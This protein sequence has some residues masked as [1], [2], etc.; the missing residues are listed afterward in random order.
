MITSRQDYLFYIQEDMRVNKWGEVSLKTHL[1]QFL[2]PNNCLRLF[3]FYLRKCEYYRNCK[4]SLLSKILYAFYLNRYSYYSVMCGFTIPMNVFGPGLSIAHRGTIVINGAAKIGANCR[5]HACVNIGTAK[6]YSTEAPTIGDN[7]YIGPGAK[8]FG[9]IY[10]AD[11][12]VI[13]ANAVVN[14][15]CYTPGTVLLGVPAK[16]IRIENIDNL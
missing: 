5:I 8:I 13:G 3:V 14:K 15:S 6:G 2:F 11:N 16:E 10:I 7:V 4:H 1:K 12:C 9:K